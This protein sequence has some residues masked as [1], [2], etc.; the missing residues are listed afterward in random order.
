MEKHKFII[1]LENKDKYFVIG[2]FIK[3]LNTGQTNVYNGSPIDP[4]GSHE[5]VAIIPASAFIIIECE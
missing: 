5:L 3:Q 4:Q 1:H 2:N